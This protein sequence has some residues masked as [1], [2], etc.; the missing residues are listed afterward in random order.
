MC[1]TGY[2]SVRTNGTIVFGIAVDGRACVRVREWLAGWLAG[3]GCGC[4][5][6]GVAV[7]CGVWD[8]GESNSV[9]RWWGKSVSE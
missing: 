2:Y 5:G 6:G 8:V 7:G 4:G 1:G 9:V 3:Y